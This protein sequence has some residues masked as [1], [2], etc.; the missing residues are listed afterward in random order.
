M[1]DAPERRSSSDDTREHILAA[2]ALVFGERGFAG[3]T[4]D[5]IAKSAGVSQAYV[6]R[7]FGSKQELF[8][9]VI[10]RAYARIT[11]TFRDGI[12]HFDGTEDIVSRTDALGEAYVTLIKDRGIL[13]S[14]MHAFTLGHDAHVGPVVRQRFLEI[15]R[16]VRDEAGVDADTAT[17]FM[18]SGM[19]I[20]TL[21]ALRIADVVDAEPDARELLT[22]V[23]G[24]STEAVVALTANAPTAPESVRR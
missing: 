2:A 4:T 7:L 1:N 23:W 20:N 11:D 18:A 5:A 19:F 8:L 10:E 24:D 9:A 17:R 21:M 12:A 13:L 15:Y 16:V 14:L 3:G 22:C 6:V